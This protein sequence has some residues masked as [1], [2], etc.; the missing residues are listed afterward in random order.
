MQEHPEELLNNDYENDPQ[1][2]ETEGLKENRAKACYGENDYFNSM[3]E[4]FYFAFL[5]GIICYIQ[6]FRQSNRWVTGPT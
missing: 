4:F 5:I 2:K 1:I 3:L 6:F